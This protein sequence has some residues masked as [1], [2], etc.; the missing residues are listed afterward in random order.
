MANVM[1]ETSSAYIYWQA[2]A[3]ANMRLQHYLSCRLR[4]AAAP[5]HSVLALTTCP[6]GNMAEVADVIQHE[7]DTSL[8]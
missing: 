6:D 7:P 2:L 1:L 3:C 8:N 4:Q 5:V